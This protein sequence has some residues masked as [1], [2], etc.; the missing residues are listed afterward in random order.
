MEFPDISR[1]LP[2]AVKNK[3]VT[4]RLKHRKRKMDQALGRLT[5]WGNA[6]DGGN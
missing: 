1:M 4:G 2:E 6:S 3:T 5:W